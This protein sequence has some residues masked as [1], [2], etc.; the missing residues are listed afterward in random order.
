MT[1]PESPNQ[2]QQNNSE[3]NFEVIEEGGR[4]PRE[5]PGSHK[6]SDGDDDE[7]DEESAE[8]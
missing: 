2:G 1:R 8:E 5:T 3:P 7:P 4:G 6:A